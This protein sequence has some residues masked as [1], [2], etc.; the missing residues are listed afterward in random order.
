MIT[1]HLGS[2]WCEIVPPRSSD[3]IMG[4]M[5]YISLSVFRGSI[6][7]IEIF[8]ASVRPAWSTYHG[9]CFMGM[10][11]GMHAGQEVSNSSML[12]CGRK[13]QRAL[14]TGFVFPR[15]RGACHPRTRSEVGL[16][17]RSRKTHEDHTTPAHSTTITTCASAAGALSVAC[18]AC[19]CWGPH[20]CRL[21]LTFSVTSRVG[22]CNC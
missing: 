4:D 17:S 2:G 19:L 14:K 21:A 11:V 20:A 10:Y 22:Y 15:W 5:M 9:T 1:C 16:E 8:G 13:Y 18:A 6:G 12:A 7:F 3:V